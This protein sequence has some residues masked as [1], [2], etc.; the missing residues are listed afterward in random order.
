MIQHKFFAAAR[1]QKYW[2]YSTI[3]LQITS[4]AIIEST[5][6]RKQRMSLSV[7]RHRER[8]CLIT[9]GLFY[10][11]PYYISGSG[12]ISVVL[13]SMQGQKAL[14][15]HQ[16]CHSLCSE[17]ENRSYMFGTTWGWVTWFSFLGELYLLMNVLDHCMYILDFMY[18][19][20]NNSL[21]CHVTDFYFFF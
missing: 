5:S 9:H 20:I 14:E 11:S 10:R 21:K 1:I 15:F 2:L 19:W 12:N 16:K 4:S 3:L 8:N 7:M 18:F 6:A 13:L 17:D